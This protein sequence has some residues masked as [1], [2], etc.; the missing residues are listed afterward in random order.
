MASKSSALWGSRA[1]SQSSR[2]LSSSRRFGT[3]PSDLILPTDRRYVRYRT[4]CIFEEKEESG[5]TQFASSD[6]R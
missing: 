5:T 1:L 6:S 4:Y 2:I 3:L